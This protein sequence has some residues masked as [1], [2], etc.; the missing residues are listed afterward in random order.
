MKF[1]NITIVVGQCN[2]STVKDGR[3]GI[4][5][6]IPIEPIK[7]FNLVQFSKGKIRGNHYHPE[8]D[9]YI[10]IVDGTFSIITIEPESKK[11]IA[12]IASKGTCLFIPSG[13]PHSL[14]ASSDATCVSFLTKCWNDCESPIL[15][16][17]MVEQDQEY[18]EYAK[19]KGFKHSHE[20]IRDK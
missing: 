20:E 1:G 9:E 17:G 15:R 3:G 10:L 4:F 11:E 6:W 16:E 19:K 7:E 2:V 8:F 13:T 14:V 12:M 18:K 5:T